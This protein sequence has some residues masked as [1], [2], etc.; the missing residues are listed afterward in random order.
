M[1][2]GL[3]RYYLMQASYWCQQFIILV[4][5]LEKPR[6]D[7]KELVAH[8]LVTLWLVGCALAFFFFFCLYTF[9]I[10]TAGPSWSYGINLTLIGNAVYMSMDIPDAFFATVKVL[11]YLRW[12]RAQNVIFVIFLVIWTWVFFLCHHAIAAIYASLDISA[13]IST[14][15]CYGLCIKT[16]T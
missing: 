15:S 5:G 16:L 10:D 3:K 14:S 9:Y 13:T 12:E 1:T 2:P 6:K 7:Y 8:H 4:L 11:N